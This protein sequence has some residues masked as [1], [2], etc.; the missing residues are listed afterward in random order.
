MRSNAI[1]LFLIAALG[2]FGMTT[3]MSGNTQVS[4]EK[5]LPH[6]PRTWDDE[7]MLSTEVPLAQSAA[8]PKYISSDFYYRIPVRPIY[9]SYP[10]YHPG[11]EPVGYMNRLKK[12]EPQVIFDASKLITEQDWIQA[13]E[14]VFD[15]AIEFVSS[16]QLFSGVRDNSWYEKNQVPITKE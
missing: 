14:N 12:E 1:K 15:A 2:F 9:R 6:I 13:G 3:S 8:S 16:G 5:W 11:K 7:A 10:V 4:K